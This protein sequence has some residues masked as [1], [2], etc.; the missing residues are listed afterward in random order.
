[1]EWVSAR[2]C[3]QGSRASVLACGVECALTEPGES[4][5]EK[6]QLTPCVPLD[7]SPANLDDKLLVGDGGQAYGRRKPRNLPRI[8]RGEDSSRCWP[9]PREEICCSVPRSLAGLAERRTVPG[10]RIPR[11]RSRPRRARALQYSWAHLPAV[12]GLRLASG[13]RRPRRRCEQS[14]DKIEARQNQSSDCTDIRSR[15]INEVPLVAVE[16]M[17]VQPRALCRTSQK[18]NA[19]KPLGAPALPNMAIQARDEVSALSRSLS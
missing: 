19:K 15:R 14:D 9:G 6:Q 18:K 1:M 12:H 16:A 13:R 11:T 10:V 7:G 3:A 4:E 17:R 5:V 8:G 2:R